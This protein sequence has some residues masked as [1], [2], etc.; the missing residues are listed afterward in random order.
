LAALLR[1][2]NAASNTA[3]D[4]VMVLEQA[5]ASLPSEHRPDRA[6]SDGIPVDARVQDAVD[7]L[8]LGEAWYPAI[9][10]D[11]IREGAWVAEATDLVDLSTW[12]PGTRLVL[13]KERPHPGAQLRFTDPDG[14][15]VTAFITDTPPGVVPGQ[16]AGLRID[17]T[18]GE[19]AADEDGYVFKEFD[20]LALIRG[21]TRNEIEELVRLEAY[22]QAMNQ[23]ARD[24]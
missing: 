3:A 24:C 14:M 4:H 6:R 17:A 12:P 23:P 10:A 1:P 21:D 7:T 8:N 9:D 5:L 11:G 20:E 15:R 19:V 22:A 2:G 13:R 18:R 16:L